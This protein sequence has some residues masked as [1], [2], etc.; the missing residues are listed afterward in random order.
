MLLH[1]AAALADDRTLA[2]DHYLKGTKQFDLGRYDAAVNE[3]MAAYE[4]K[5]DPALLYNIAQA[6]RLAGH[7]A[8]AL[9][10]YRRFLLKAPNTPQRDD[11]EQKISE[12]EK[13][14]EQQNRA[15]N[16]PP[17][18]TIRP[19]NTNETPAP[20]APPPVVPAPRVVQP[21]S[22]VLPTPPSAEASGSG[23]T[24]K[25]AG[26]ITGVS[27]MALVG[28]GIAFAVLAQSASNDLTQLDRN[29]QTYDPA[30]YDAGKLD[31]TLAGVFL[32]VGG[33]AAAAGAVVYLLGYRETHTA[34]LHASVVPMVSP[35]LAGAAVR[36]G[37]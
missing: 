7:A 19:N 28:V 16:M 14:V 15:Q 25:L 36:F 4:L 34:G 26:L 1:G 2:R 33:A 9:H 30:K 18:S 31:Q 22:P 17:D 8:Q 29:K 21:P 20:V 3:Y 10:F 13:L 6:H 24:K 5:D 35:N 27:G 32:G 11:V 23:R 37:F 12:L